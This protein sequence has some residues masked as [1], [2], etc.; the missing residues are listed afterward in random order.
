LQYKYLVRI[1]IISGIFY[2]Y[3]VAINLLH[4]HVGKAPILM[5]KKLVGGS[6]SDAP[7]HL[8]KEISPNKHFQGFGVF[9]LSLPCYGQDSII[10][11]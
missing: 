8:K 9:I 7:Q 10:E 11:A 3:E 6:F 5:Y 2:W 1:R 4:S